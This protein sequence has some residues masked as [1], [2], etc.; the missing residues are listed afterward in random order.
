ML[1][2]S[3][4]TAAAEFETE[5]AQRAAFLTALADRGVCAPPDVARAVAGYPNPPA[6]ASEGA[7]A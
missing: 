6:T 1:A 3:L 2:A 5:L 4:G 7:S